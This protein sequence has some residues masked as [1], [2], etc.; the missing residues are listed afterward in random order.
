MK[1]LSRS[2][3]RIADVSSVE[4]RR[5][6]L[7]LVVILTALYP[8][9]AHAAVCRDFAGLIDIGGGRKMYIECGDRGSPTVVLISG[10]AGA[11]IAWTMPD[12]AK[13]GPTV[14]SEVA[15]FTRVFLRHG[16]G[17]ADSEGRRI[18]GLALRRY[19][20]DDRADFG[21]PFGEPFREVAAV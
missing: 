12:P 20:G 2:T 9:A 11:A 19:R 18:S 8:G 6:F 10:E 13:P 5:V 4:I 17:R 1:S 7:L 15:R 21:Q 3:A 16:P 14:F